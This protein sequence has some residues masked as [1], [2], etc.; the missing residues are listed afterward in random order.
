MSDFDDKNK[1]K[2]NTI[3]NNSDCFIKCDLLKEDN[4]CIL[5][6]IEMAKNN[7][8]MCIKNK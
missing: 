4:L 3:I 2:L 8:I 1:C 7:F 5:N 6:S